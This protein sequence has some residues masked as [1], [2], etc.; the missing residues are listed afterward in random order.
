MDYI[1]QEE[2]TGIGTSSGANDR[3]GVYSGVRELFNVMV[4]L[5]KYYSVAHTSGVIKVDNDTISVQNILLD[6]GATDSS[7]VSPVFLKKYS[8]QLSKY[9]YSIGSNTVQLG[10]RNNNVIISEAINLNVELVSDNGKNYSSVIK[11]HILDIHP[12]IIIGLPDIV[13]GFNSFFCEKITLA[14][15]EHQNK[16]YDGFLSV[17]DLQH[18]WSKPICDLESLEELETPIP[19]SF[20]TDEM[21]SFL[22]P[23]AYQNSV[24]KY[25]ELYS[26]HVAPEFSKAMPVY[27]LLNTKGLKV[28]C[29]SEWT[30][31]S[32][33]DP[34]E[35]DW[36][37]D[38]PT[39]YRPRIRVV[40]PKLWADAEKEV[41]RLQSYLWVPSNSN[42]ASPLVVAP[43]ATDPFI[44]MCIDLTYMNKF[45]K[46]PAFPMKH[47][48]QN[49]NKIR[50]FKYFL[51][52]DLTNG[53][54]Q[55]KLG[56]NTSEKLSVITWWGLFRPLFMPEGAKPA[57]QIFQHVMNNVFKGFEEF[58]IVIMDNVLVLCHDYQDAYHKLE[59]VLDRCLERNVHLKFSKSWL[60]FSKVNFYGYVCEHNSYRLSDDRKEAIKVI[61]FPKNQ[62][63]AQ[64]VMGSGVFFKPFVPNYSTISASLY[65][66]T[67]KDFNWN[68]LLW[69]KDYLNIFS[70]PGIW[71]TI[72]TKLCKKMTHRIILATI[73]FSIHTKLL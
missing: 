28:F 20:P 72:K 67:K 43:K 19:K 58:L 52:L 51:D 53:Y 61:P 12:D 33:M 23:G 46:L 45:M 2:R 35:F 48:L 71:R 16:I 44:R 47:V 17:L 55:L 50:G 66:L 15:D 65:E 59:L 39:E 9:K 4:P 14:A 22:T 37:E 64:R 8:E 63:Q 26:T 36:T 54:H 57:A 24:E 56:P 3:F 30:G 18:P 21:F 13:S 42:I 25:Y 7:Y 5:S 31:I 10:V 69:K 11:C 49:L 41:N 38:C 60:G 27:E 73:D 70:F 6:T 29:P 40:N 62:K 68:K 34:I 1:S 32:G